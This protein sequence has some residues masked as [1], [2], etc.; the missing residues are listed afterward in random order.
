[1]DISVIFKPENFEERIPV[2]SVTDIHNT[3]KRFKS[4][5]HTKMKVLSSFTHSQVPNILKNVYPNS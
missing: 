5:V 3:V 1:M 2:T 4:I